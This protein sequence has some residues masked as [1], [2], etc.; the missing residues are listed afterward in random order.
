MA[1]RVWYGSRSS[2]RGG[3]KPAGLCLVGEIRCPAMTKRRPPRRPNAAPELD[4]IHPLTPERIPDLAKLFGQGGDPKWCWCSFFRVRGP[5][6]NTLTSRRDLI[7]PNRKVMTDALRTTAAEGRAPGLVATATARRSDGSA[8][9]RARTSIDLSTRRSSRASTSGRSGRSSA[10]LW[11]SA[12]VRHVPVLLA[13]R[14]THRRLGKTV[15]QRA[16]CVGDR[17]LLSKDRVGD[18]P[19]G[20]D[21][22]RIGLEGGGHA[23]VCRFPGHMRS[24]RTLMPMDWSSSM[25]SGFSAA[26]MSRQRA[27]LEPSWP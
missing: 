6:W 9:D 11:A 1:R 20:D 13:T 10:S 12:T 18:L 4:G 14:R 5:S 8:S 19:G 16:Q 17:L 7:R 15:E 25:T 2:K 24:C 3:L 26:R 27:R 21:I 23:G 22:G